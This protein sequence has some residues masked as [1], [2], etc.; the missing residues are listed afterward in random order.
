MKNNIYLKARYLASG[1]ILIF[2]ALALSGLPAMR[3]WAGSSQTV[4]DADRG[5]QYFV[6][7]A[8]ASAATE[9]ILARINQDFLNS[10][11]ALVYLNLPF[12]SGLIPTPLDDSNWTNYIFFNPKT[13]V[14]NSVYVDRFQPATNMPLNGVWSG[15]YGY[16]STYRIFANAESA[17]DR[18]GISA[19][20][21]Q[22]NVL[23]TSVPIFEYAI[24]Y[25]GLMEFSDTATLNVI[26]RVHANSNIYV[27]SPQNLTFNSLVTTTGTI[28]SPAN[29]GYAASTW[30]GTVTYNGAPSP[31]YLTGQPALIL[32]VGTNSTSS[33][34]VQQI[35]YPPPVGESS[36]SP[37]GQQRYY[38]KAGLTLIISNVTFTAT[39]KSTPNDPAPYVLTT[40]LTYLTNAAWNWITT[41]NSFMDWRENK[42]VKVTQIDVGKMTNW[43]GANGWLS[44]NTVGV[45]SKFG[46]NNPFNILYVAD[47]RTTNSSTLTAVRL[48]N[49][50]NLPSTGLTV[51][52]PNPLYIQGNYN[53]L[54]QY[55]GT[56][57]TTLSAPASVV[58]DALTIL[59]PAWVDSGSATQL[60]QNSTSDTLNTAIITGNVPSTGS[61]SSQFSGGVSNLPR[62]LEKWNS[63]TLT[64][65]TSL[66]CLFNSTRATG[67]FVLPGTYY[68]PPIVRQF[69]FDQNFLWPSGMPPGTPVFT[70]PA[71]RAFQ[72]I[73]NANTVP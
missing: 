50:T 15:L 31:G 38:N 14:T 73:G 8:A 17:N 43:M 72:K 5:S 49:G 63:A 46:F 64:L 55:Y 26:G 66:V 12:Y 10:G 28:S 52:T 71:T 53:C 34:N 9:K 57:N 32:P 7:A 11:E 19:A 67:Q 47:S 58:C 40:N 3:T 54:P 39:F 27:G 60:N 62:L 22:L 1:G 45:A 37:L 59:S 35:L 48:V 69:S 13:G 65:N 44:T 21:A 70:L 30:T 4:R 29:S 33:T 18:G 6:N 68:L 2:I 36:S 61:G 25:N 51:A 24:F 23:V 42:T 56:T 41:T 20:Q 16:A